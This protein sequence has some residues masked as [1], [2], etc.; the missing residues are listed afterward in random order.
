M[1]L[2][3][4][5]IFFTILKAVVLLDPLPLP[6]RSFLKKKKRIRFINFISH[7]SYPPVRMYTTCMSGAHRDKRG[8]NSVVM[9]VCE[10]P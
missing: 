1:D 5:W 2:Y 4:T 9:D 6:Y 3:L 10:P 8:L 7:E